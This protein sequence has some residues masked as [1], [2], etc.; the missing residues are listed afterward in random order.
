VTAAD[1][2]GS[3]GT[4]P[5]A[6]SLRREMD[7]WSVEGP[8]SAYA[9]RS[10]VV[11]NPA[12]GQ[13]DRLRLVRQIGGAL[14]VRGAAFDLVETTGPGDA[15]V[16]ARRAAELGYRSVL[17][18]GGDGTVAEV[19]TGLAGTQVPLAIVP[20]G[21]A[22]QVAGNLRI[23]A[24][25][26][27]AVEVAVSGIPV[28]MDV[29]VLGDGR[30][31]ALIAGA[32]WDAEVMAVAT[33]QLKDRWGFG[34]YLYACLRKAISPPSAQFRITA[35]GRE[36]EIRAATVLI[37]NVGQ[38]FH[39]LLPVDLRIAPRGSFSDGLLDICI[40]APRNLPD[41]AAVLWKMARRSYWGDERMIYL[42]VESIRIEADPPVVTQVDGDPSGETPLEARVV[43]GG[44]RVMVPP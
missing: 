38:L 28:P 15:A 30:Y 24:D 11:V 40:F 4:P 37:A 14:A 34:A 2:P 23:P 41:V 21:T 8:V 26:E 17:A 19:I 35:D 36:F 13:E 16:H 18:V 31:F 10:L 7:V 12:A 44:V 39:E 29:G 42:Q 20:Q 43:P 1:A 22:N 6:D 5:P 32:G 9:S 3:P 27:R 33:R 25:V